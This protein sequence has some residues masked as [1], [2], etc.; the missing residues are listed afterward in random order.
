MR[1]CINNSWFR[2][3]I[4]IES[5]DILEKKRKGKSN[6]LYLSNMKKKVI[7]NWFS[8]LVTSGKLQVHFHLSLRTY[9]IIHYSEKKTHTHTSFSLLTNEYF[10]PINVWHSSKEK[11]RKRKSL[12]IH[13]IILLEYIESREFVSTRYLYEKKKKVWN[14]NQFDEFVLSFIIWLSSSSSS[15]SSSYTKL[16][17]DIIDK[18]LSNV[19]FQ[20][21]SISNNKNR[22]RWFIKFRCSPTKSTFNTKSHCA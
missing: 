13:L 19:L 22:T 20:S 6:S 16:S 18:C 1:M 17:I 2:W 15:P 8:S 5:I 10:S 21:L 14:E 3:C 9:L 7:F 11:E 4:F 12:E